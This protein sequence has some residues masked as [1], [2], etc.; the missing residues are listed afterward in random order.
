MTGDQKLIRGL[1]RQLRKGK[2]LHRGIEPGSD[3]HARMTHKLDVLTTIIED[4]E[5]VE[6]INNEPEG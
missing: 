2:R 6:R 3:A 1:R 5:L 4:L